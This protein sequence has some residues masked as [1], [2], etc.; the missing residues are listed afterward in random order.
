MKDTECFTY[1]LLVDWPIPQTRGR[2]EIQT[3]DICKTSEGMF[4]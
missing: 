2:H 3:M 4:L 1:G